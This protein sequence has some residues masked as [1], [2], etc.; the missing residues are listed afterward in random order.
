MNQKSENALPFYILM[1]LAMTAWGGAWVSA[2]VVAGMSS[3]QILV[4]WR[5]LLTG[6][7]MIP[8]LLFRKE[9]FLLPRKSILPIS[10]SALFLVSYSIFFFKGLETGLAG[11]G[12]VLLTTINPLFTYVITAILF[13][14][15][16]TQKEWIGLALGL[17]AGIFL[18]KLWQFSYKELVQSGN[19]FFLLGALL[20]SFLAISSSKAQ[21]S[22]SL[23]QYSFY[24]NVFSALL[25][26]GAINVTEM[27][28]IVYLPTKFWWNLAYLSF[29]GTTFGTTAYFLSTNRLGAAKGS[30]FIFLVPVNAVVLSFLILGE[31]PQ[32]FTILGGALAIGAVYIIHR[33][34]KS[35]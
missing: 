33:S 4:F 34:P 25:I 10:L 31:E 29:I 3:P 11:A 9:S 26:L 8:I 20:W 5:Y 22:C 35:N 1:I 17:V 12:G 28:E 6:L 2:K 18:L 27:R 15:K 14:K 30:S 19:L 13:R 23:F 32:I 7:S 21:D 16:V 24:L